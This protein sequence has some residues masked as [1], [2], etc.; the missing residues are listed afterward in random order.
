MAELAVREGNPRGTLSADY[1]GEIELA[2]AFQPW[3]SQGIPGGRA[4]PS[5]HQPSETPIPSIAGSAGAAASLSSHT[6]PAYYLVDVIYAHFCAERSEYADM[7]RS[8]SI[9]RLILWALPAIIL[10]TLAG[11]FTSERRLITE[12]NAVTPLPDKFEYVHLDNNGK[13][14]RP[15]NN[16]FSSVERVGFEYITSESPDLAMSFALIDKNFGLYL[17]QFFRK[18]GGGNAV[19]AFAV[20]TESV[21]QLTIYNSPDL[22]PTSTPDGAKYISTSRPF[23]SSNDSVFSDFPH[24]IAA[25]K[26]L[27]NKTTHDSE[28]TAILKWASD[29]YALAEIQRQIAADLA[30]PTL[31]DAAGFQQFD[32]GSYNNTVLMDEF[33]WNA[34]QGLS[35]PMV[36]QYTQGFIEMLKQIQGCG[37]TISDSAYATLEGRA[38]EGQLRAMFDNDLRNRERPMPGNDPLTKPPLQVYQPSIQ[39]NLD[40]RL[41]FSR[42][43]C[44]SAEARQVLQNMEAWAIN[45]HN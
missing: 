15:G 33:Y 45:P 2:C 41:F 4:A 31:R 40:A 37:H 6:L 9:L 14:V 3:R 43:G 32:Q 20:V 27:V 12:S 1:P 19:Y 42:H 7:I 23:G 13:I 11:C 8:A 44:S 10:I 39:G 30:L 16:P 25:A 21:R 5:G 34:T 29:R 36:S 26:A 22:G 24:L 17:L 18:D 38:G 28:P 35:I